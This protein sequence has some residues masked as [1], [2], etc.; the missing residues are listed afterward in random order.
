MGPRDMAL[1]MPS[2]FGSSIQTQNVYPDI[3]TL[4]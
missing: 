3:L 1:C 4:D 2:V